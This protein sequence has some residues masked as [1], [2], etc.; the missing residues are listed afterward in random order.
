MDTPVSLGCETLDQD[1]FTTYLQVIVSE[2]IVTTRT[3]PQTQIAI[4]IVKPADKLSS[5]AKLSFPWPWR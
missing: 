5:Y 2:K 3:M 4:A 1:D